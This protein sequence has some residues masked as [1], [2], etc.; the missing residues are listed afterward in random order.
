MKVLLLGG[1]RKFWHA[2]DR[3]HDRDF[4]SGI[5][6]WIYSFDGDYSNTLEATQDLINTYDLIIGNSNGGSYAPKL[7]ELQR[8]RKKGIRWVTLIEGCATEYLTLDSTTKELFDSS[9]L[10]NVINRHSLEFFR[11]C[12]SARCE[13][14]GIP[15]PGATIREKFAAGNRRDVWIA[16][17]L[18]HYRTSSSSALAAL[19]V[20]RA[21]GTNTH[22]FLRRRPR[23]R[24]FRRLI[25]DFK[26]PK[27]QDPYNGILPEIQFHKEMHMASYFQLISDSAYTFVNLDHRYTWARDVLDCAALQIPCIA[28]LSTGHAED[29]F[30]TLMVPNEFA[31]SESSSLLERLYSDKK[32]YEECARV[33]VELFQHL[34]HSSMKEKLLAALN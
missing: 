2:S 27:I 1:N 25:P 16:S 24:G 33:P 9:D 7:L 3:L 5:E 12:T 32:F 26:R 21:M 28:T 31:V 6:A 18:Y 13:Y 14:I 23:K 11:S 29:Y 20:T 19:P 8:N 34:T 4:L 22:A 17:N 30:P 15:Y 10:I